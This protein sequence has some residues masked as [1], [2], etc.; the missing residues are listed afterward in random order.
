MSI[1][2][3]EHNKIAY[4]ASIEMLSRT[5]KAA[6]IHPTGTGKSFIGFKLCEDFPDKTICWLSPSEYIFQTQLENLKKTSKGFVPENISFYTYAKLMNLVQDEMKEICPD[7]IILDEFH[8][9]GAAMWGQGV[10]RLLKLFPN[11]PILGLSATAIRYLDNQRDMSDEIFD[12]NVAS[13]I[14]LGEALVRGV[15]TPPK[16]I[17]A[18]YSYKK[19]FEKYQHRVINVKNKNI[20]NKS[21]DYLEALRRAIE[22]ADGLDV[23]FQKHITDIS[24]RYIVFCANK[25]HLDEM[26]NHVSDWFGKIDLNPEIYIAYSED[27]ETSS[28]FAA[29]KASQSNH[30]KLLF[31]IDMLNEGIHV[32]DVS[33]VILFRPTVSPIVF[34]QQ[35]GRALCSGDKKGSVIFDIVDNIS[36]LYSI[37]AIQEEMDEAIAFYNYR[38]ESKYIVNETFHI[39]DEAQDCRK[40][41]DELEQTLSISW[42]CMFQEAKKYYQENGDLLP[43]QRY[44]TEDGYKLGQWLVTQ[45]INWIKKDP[46]L[47][48]NRIKLLESIGM[49]WLGKK[50]IIW[51]KNYSFAREFFNNNGHL[52]IPINYCPVDGVFLGIWYRTIKKSYQAGTLP[53]EKQH[54]LELIGMK[55]DSVND[56]T[57]TKNYEIAKE[58][59]LVHGDL[60][61]PVDFVTENG[62]SLGAWIS[63]QRERYKKKKLEQDRIELLNDIGMSW[64]QFGNKW[65]FG[66]LQAEKYFIKHGNL[67][68]KVDY[69]TE[70]DF[71]LGVWIANQRARYAKKQLTDSRIQVLE[72]L[73]MVWSPIEAFWRE[74]YEQAK[75]YFHS[76]GN[77]DIASDYMSEDGF[78]LG[79]W[80]SR[81]RLNFKQNKI[82]VQQKELL[83]QIGMIWDRND[84]RW[85]EGYKHALEYAKGNDLGGISQKYCSPDGYRLG[86]WISTQK[87]AYQKNKLS[88]ARVVALK[89]LGLFCDG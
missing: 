36:N 6:I 3:F 38:G 52:D 39:I 81:Q 2:L 78:L 50:D 14:T 65:K 5:G 10:K 87:K 19:D 51:E 8:R 31:C 1:S 29:F 86:D 23:V 48:P 42:D 40:L 74:G 45:R 43:P 7:Y 46:S 21:S 15:L 56:R 57:W 13:T 76:Q 20:R 60:N 11:V 80:I 71:K 79:A 66:F 18:L 54:Q 22:K 63:Y 89:E 12:G 82:S 27:P 47:T 41:F 44:V 61:V 33:G 85:Q 4:E 55:W 77:L 49:Q 17:T 84:L 62:D 37:A 58:Y 88:E 68:V 64:H 9:C 25:N 34:K 24:G 69:V 75:C 73:K 28:A 70:D 26:V 83:D 30:L 16:Y 72:S 35:I 59:Y 53:V 32:K 67:N